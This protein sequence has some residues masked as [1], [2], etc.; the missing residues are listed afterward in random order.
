[1]RASTGRFISLLGS[2]I[3]IGLGIGLGFR[4][5][6][7]C[8][9]LVDSSAVAIGSRRTGE[10]ALAHCTHIAESAAKTAS[11]AATEQLCVSGGANCQQAGQC[12]AGEN[13]TISIHD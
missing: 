11:R 2:R 4:L 6:V 7:S 9:P 3:G 12:D 8:G 10:P 13:L 1:M 5:G